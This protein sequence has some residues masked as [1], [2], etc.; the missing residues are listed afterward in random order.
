MSGKHLSALVA[1]CWTLLAGIAAAPSANG[2]DPFGGNSFFELELRFARWAF[3]DLDHNGDRDVSGPDDGIIYTLEGGDAGWTRDEMEIIEESFQVWED[4]PSSFVAFKFTAPIEDPIE[5]FGN[6]GDD[7]VLFV[8]GI[9]FVAA[10]VP[11]EPFFDG[12]VT[13]GVLGIAY[14][15]VLIDDGFFETPDGDIGVFVEGGGRIYECDIVIN[16]AAHRSPGGGVPASSDLKGT[17][18]HEIGHSLGIGH[19]P[20]NN[21]DLILDDDG[22]IIGALENP[23]VGMRDA[24]GR[25]ALHG[26]TPTMFPVVFSVQDEDSQI[27]DD[28]GADLAWDD[29]AAVTFLYPRTDQSNFFSMSSHARSQASNGFPSF[30]ILGGLVTAWVDTDNSPNTQRVPLMSTI[31]GLYT[32]VEDIFARGDFTIPNLPKEIEH[33]A[34][35][36]PFNPTYT[37]TIEPVRGDEIPGRAVGEDYDTTHFFRP[38]DQWVGVAY[39]DFFP[40]ETFLEEGELFGSN[41]HDAGTAFVF[42]QQ[43]DRFVS[44][45]SGRTLNQLLRGGAPMF[46]DEDQVCPLDII[47]QAVLLPILPNMLR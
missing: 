37:F 11:G 7:S 26:V 12:T 32:F 45:S 30:P 40:S 4:V 6:I 1:G 31:T 13:G 42:D 44:T 34:I 38:E 9:R 20:M 16:A 23:V 24:Q 29:V 18:V 15:D 19:T 10:N 41:N 5:V 21:L 28:G 39:A 35:S 2:F 33:P 27:R 43:R 25:L 3:E 22:E 46:G 17:M 36:G 14:I 47:D 8:D